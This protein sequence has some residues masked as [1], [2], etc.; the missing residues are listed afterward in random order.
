MALAIRGDSGE[1]VWR[2]GNAAMVA[3]QCVAIRGDVCVYVY[4]YHPVP[5][6]ERDVDRQNSE[7]LD[8]IY[9]Y[10]SSL[11]RGH[12]RRGPDFNVQMN[13]SI[14]SSARSHIRGSRLF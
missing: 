10:I 13:S 8:L 9:I 7:D 11:M 1:N 3:A 12:I 6:A 2:C 5:E 14:H 4:I